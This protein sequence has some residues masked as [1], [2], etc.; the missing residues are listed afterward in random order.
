MMLLSVQ[1]SGGGLIFKESVSALDPHQVNRQ[2]E[3]EDFHTQAVMPCASLTLS[4]FSSSL[5]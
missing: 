3:P 2:R 4:S 5:N 1:P